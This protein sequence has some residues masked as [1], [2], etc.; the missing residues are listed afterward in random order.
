M[1]GI[2]GVVVKREDWAEDRRRREEV[3]GGKIEMVER[4]K[5]REREK[6]VVRFSLLRWVQAVILGCGWSKPYPCEQ[7]KQS[8]RPPGP[9][10]LL[11]WGWATFTP[12]VALSS[13]ADAGRPLKAFIT[14][15]A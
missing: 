14:G 13:L 7:W 12:L 1:G 5:D 8:W 15:E 3:E 11:P 2:G 9:P 10:A 4:V 6:G